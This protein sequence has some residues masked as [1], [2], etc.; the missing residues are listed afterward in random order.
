[1]S[2]ASNIPLPGW[3]RGLSEALAAAYV[4]LSVSQFRT[5]V[6]AG[7]AP[8]P[9]RITQG[10]KIWLKDDLDTYLDRIFGKGNPAQPP[11]TLREDLEEW[12][13]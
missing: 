6:K 12:Q 13:A 4:S 10:R 2:K 11:R 5:E 8:G 3:P 1:M 9:G 7:R